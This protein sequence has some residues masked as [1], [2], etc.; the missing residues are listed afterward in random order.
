M[1]F[2]EKLSRYNNKWCL[3]WVKRSFCSCSM[4]HKEERY[5]IG[6]IRVNEDFVSVRGPDNDCLYIREELIDAF[7][8]VSSEEQ[9]TLETALQ[10]SIIKSKLKIVTNSSSGKKDE[11]IK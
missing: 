8:I 9:Q 3:L 4:N 5:I 2:L 11:V 7:E 10:K 1:T 6:K